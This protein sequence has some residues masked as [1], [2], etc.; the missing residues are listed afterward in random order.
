VHPSEVCISLSSSFF[1]SVDYSYG[2][3]LN[4]FKLHSLSAQR[5]YL[6]VFL[7]VFFLVVLS[8]FLPFWKLLTYVCQIKILETL[9]Y[10]MSTSDIETAFPL[11]AL[12][13]QMPSTLILIHLMRVNVIT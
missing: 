2:N 7:K 10:L 3:V 1:K 11:N 4:Y 9:P 12:Q 5:H 8:S 6:G 13:W